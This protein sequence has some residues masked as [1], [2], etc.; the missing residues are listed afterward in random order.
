MHKTFYI[1]CKTYIQTSKSMGKDMDENPTMYVLVHCQ[2]IVLS[3]ADAVANKQS[4]LKEIFVL[5]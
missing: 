3:V 1:L 5:N 2:N 4:L